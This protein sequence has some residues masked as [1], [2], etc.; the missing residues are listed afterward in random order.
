[1]DIQK[2]IN[3]FQSS[4]EVD[5][6]KLVNLSENEVVIKNAFNVNYCNER[7]IVYFAER[8]IEANLPLFGLNPKFLLNEYNLTL[9]STSGSP[10]KDFS[11]EVSG[12][13]DGY[14]TNY[15]PD[16]CLSING[17]TYYIEY[18]V[19]ESSFS[20]VKMANDYLK[21][22]HYTYESKVDT[23]FIF[24][25]FTKE[26]MGSIS[27]PTLR[28]D[29]LKDPKYQ[30]IFGD[31]K[32]EDID[33]DARV[34]I[35]KSAI[36]KNSIDLVEVELIGILDEIIDNSGPFSGKD[37]DEKFSTTSLIENNVFYQSKGICGSNVLTSNFIKENYW[38][39]DNLY[40]YF[41]S[42]SLKY[43]SNNLKLSEFEFDE[44]AESGAYFNNTVKNLN[45]NSRA[46]MND[47][48]YNITY[49]KSY[50]VIYLLKKFC[51]NNNLNFFDKF[52]LYNEK[53]QND[54]LLL[55][56]EIGYFHKDDDATSFNYLCYKLTYLIHGLFDLLYVKDDNGK[57]CE[58][59]EIKYSKCKS[60]II[61]NIEKIKARIGY[62]QREK[63]NYEKIESIRDVAI[64]ILISSLNK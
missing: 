50:W 17:E 4:I 11:F 52:T 6:L 42:N 36:E 1:M 57:L 12:V 41:L 13:S 2:F 19:C 39:I 22:R 23:Y 62:K 63:I 9:N 33:F 45:K 34:F 3:K 26:K 5:Y 59:P 7:T 49:R 32:R 27:I 21:Y 31:I 40:N 56:K 35:K 30:I 8:F 29:T 10:M 38:M 18:K 44:F 54:Y 15:I 60:R 48:S 58:K 51:E 24:V 14:H 47:A 61:N 20:Y 37:G 64:S 43:F 28:Y 46:L 25:N 53:M 16:T 55:A